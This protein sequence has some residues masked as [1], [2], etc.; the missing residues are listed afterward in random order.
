M[1][2]ARVPFAGKGVAGTEQGGDIIIEQRAVELI[3]A[4][5]GDQGELTQR[6]VLCAIVS[7]AD[8]QFLD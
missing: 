5:L 2:N 8:L 7:R 1:N 6:A 4:G 3:S